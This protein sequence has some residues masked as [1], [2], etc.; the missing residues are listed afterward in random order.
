MNLNIYLESRSLV[1]IVACQDHLI[2]VDALIGHPEQPKP[3]PLISDLS[4]VGTTA[5][6]QLNL[7][8]L[9]R[10]TLERSNIE[11][12]HRIRQVA[13]IAF[14]SICSYLGART[15]GLRHCCHRQ[16]GKSV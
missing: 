10:V 15:V 2:N 7:C 13:F 11:P 8:Q 14:F 5:L 3:M 16:K 9:V 4:E 6:L 1:T 12:V